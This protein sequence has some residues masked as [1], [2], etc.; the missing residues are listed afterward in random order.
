MEDIVSPD[1]DKD[2][3]ELAR[4]L[5]LH[6]GGKT[7][8]LDLREMGF[9]T[10]YFVIVTA[11]SS[12]HMHGLMKRIK[13]FL[14]EKGMEPLRKHAGGG[15]DDWCLVDSGD[16]IVHIMSE[17]ARAFYELEKL[18]FQAKVAFSSD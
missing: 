1:A 13:D 17:R 8:V 6:N 9:W 10:D 18:W 5:K 12:T 14:N 2:V 15:E 4:M 16:F 11:T 3:I 7:L